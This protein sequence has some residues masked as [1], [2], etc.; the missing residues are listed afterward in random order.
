MT[1]SRAQAEAW[2]QAISEAA[3]VQWRGGR[4]E[5]IEEHC[6]LKMTFSLRESRFRRTAVANLLKPTI[7]GLASHLFVSGGPGHP[8]PWT[9]ADHRIVSLDA[10]K[11][12]SSY[13]GVTLV[14]SPV[15]DWLD[16]DPWIRGEWI[17]LGGRPAVWVSD[18]ER[19]WKERI[20]NA[21][22]SAIV[23]PLRGPAELRL[24]FQIHAD[25]MTRLD[26]DTLIYPAVQG[27]TRAIYQPPRGSQDFHRIIAE[28]S[29]IEIVKTEGLLIGIRET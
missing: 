7:D 26:L 16:T 11:E 23:D 24:S 8:G 13:S 27:I 1:A 21:V 22:R 12:S 15:I 2:K 28:K 25:R 6:H 20:T 29:P 14:L 4:T 10:R 5:Y 18:Q 19:E 17:Y 9:R 3:N